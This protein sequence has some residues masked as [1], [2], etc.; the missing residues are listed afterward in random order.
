MSGT[1]QWDDQWDELLGDGRID[2]SKWGTVRGTVRTASGLPPGRCGIWGEPTTVPA[3]GMMA[4]ALTTR[5]D[6]SYQLR[7][8]AATYTINVQGTSPSGTT[9][10]AEVPGVILSGGCHITVDITVTEEPD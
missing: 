6:G 7:L 2:W 4:K 10:T 3:D 9:L 8:P 5:P 1:S